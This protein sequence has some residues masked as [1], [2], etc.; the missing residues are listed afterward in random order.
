MS[1]KMTRI[2]IRGKGGRYG[3]MD[4]GEKSFE[5]MKANIR[6]KAENDLEA[7]TA[8]LNATDDDFECAIVRGPYVQHFVREVVPA[9]PGIPESE[10]A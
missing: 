8:I 3:F 4:W 10:A 5:E 1:E 9:H 6:R 2:G 7:A